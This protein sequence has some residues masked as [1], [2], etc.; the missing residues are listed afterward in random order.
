MVMP[1][2]LRLVPAVA[3]L[4]LLAA[5]KQAVP[6]DVAAKVNDRSITY[7]ELDKQYRFQIG[8]MS[9]KPSEDQL[10]Y[11]KLELL[12]TLVDNEIMLQRAEK[13]NLMATE[14]EVDAKFN[15]LKTP[16]T[17]EEFS[18]R[19]SAS[20]NCSTRRSPPRSTSPIKRSPIS[21]TPAKPISTSP[22]PTCISRRS[23]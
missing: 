20:T 2:R 17:Q 21:T 11:Q 12:R 16:Y 14:S 9:E 3:A 15:E 1:T 13:A 23:L 10:N 22:S 8:N 19:T 5:C 4:S 18:A 7:A 6:P